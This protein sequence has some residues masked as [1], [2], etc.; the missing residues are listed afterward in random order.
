MASLFTTEQNDL[1]KFGRR[2][3]REHAGMIVFKIYPLVEEKMSF[4]GFSNLRRPSS[5]TELNGLSN[6]GRGSPKEPSCEIISKSVY[7]YSRR[8]CLK[9]FSLLISQAAILFNATVR[10]E[11]F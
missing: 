10:F 5:S 2:K 3:P 7:Q 11:Q 1:T 4:K 6:F 9:L 8:N